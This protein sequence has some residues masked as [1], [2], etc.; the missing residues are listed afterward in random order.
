M[1]DTRAADTS[2]AEKSGGSHQRDRT[3]GFIIASFVIAIFWACVF[4]HARRVLR[5]MEWISSFRPQGASPEYGSSFALVV[6]RVFG[7]AGTAMGVMFASIAL[8]A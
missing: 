4:W 1:I 8:L 3:M 7:F 6:V 2:S 5:I